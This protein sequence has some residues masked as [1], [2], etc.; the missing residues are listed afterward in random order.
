M[1][2]IGADAQGRIQDF[3]TA[4]VVAVSPLC[5]AISWLIFVCEILVGVSLEKYIKKSSKLF[6]YFG[7]NGISKTNMNEI[8]VS[9]PYLH[10]PLT[11]NPH[12]R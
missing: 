6:T 11:R 4:Y 8:F 9:V 5:Y 2:N 1:H 3:T 7:N 12:N 10:T